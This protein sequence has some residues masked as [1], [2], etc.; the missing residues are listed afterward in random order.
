MRYPQTH[1]FMSIQQN[2]AYK[3]T[4]YRIEAHLRFAHQRSVATNSQ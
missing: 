4:N 1:S 2:F 3:H